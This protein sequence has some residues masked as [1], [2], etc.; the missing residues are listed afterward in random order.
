V[1]GG[2]VWEGGVFEGGQGVYRGEASRVDGLMNAYSPTS[3]L[4]DDDRESG[5]VTSRQS[6]ISRKCDRESERS[7]ASSRQ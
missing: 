3:L 2:G 6:V 4:G 1:A 7:V 5:I